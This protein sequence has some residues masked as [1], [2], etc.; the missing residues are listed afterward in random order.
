MNRFER[1]TPMGAEAEIE[2]LDGD[3][4]IV[5][6]GTFVRCGVTGDPI[7][8]A[9]LR[10]WNVERQ[11]AYSGPEAVLTRLGSRAKA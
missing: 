4:R 5:R 8:L 3:Y 9:E 2:Y 6:H 10:Y 1:P 11:E 7:P